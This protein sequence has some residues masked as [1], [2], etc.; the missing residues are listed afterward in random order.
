M[1]YLTCKYYWTSAGE[2]N[3]Q[4]KWISVITSVHLTLFYFFE[5]I[6]SLF[7]FLNNIVAG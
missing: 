2:E 6:S 5:F 4:V 1:N 3:E 7:V